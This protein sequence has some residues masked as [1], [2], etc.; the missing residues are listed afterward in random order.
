MNNLI[1]LFRAIGERTARSTP[2]FLNRRL[3]LRIGCTAALATLAVTPPIRVP[4]V[5]ADQRS[6]GSF[7][8]RRDRLLQR[9]SLAIA[10]RLCRH[11]CWPIRAPLAE[12]F[13]ARGGLRAGLDFSAPEG[14]PVAAAYYGTV[15]FAGWDGAYGQVVQIRHG[16]GVVTCYAHCGKLLV[17]PG[18]RVSAGQ[19]IAESGMTGRSLAPGLH[20][21]L[22]VNGLAVNPFAAL[23]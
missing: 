21:E 4:T 22:L 6:A 23:S 20:F 13:G 19:A 17:A 10:R 8:Q 1:F 11:L 18:D 7:W 9:Q 3:L 15:S 5:S 16:H 2:L 12:G 14:T